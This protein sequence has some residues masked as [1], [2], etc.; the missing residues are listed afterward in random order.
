MRSFEEILGDADVRTA[1][2]NGTSFD[3][4]AYDW[5]YV[6]RQDEN[7]ECPIL[8]AAML[9]V[10]PSEWVKTGLQDYECTEFEPQEEKQ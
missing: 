5:C 2:S 3:I 7:S 1:F 10:T 6:C 4:W 8:L 9:N